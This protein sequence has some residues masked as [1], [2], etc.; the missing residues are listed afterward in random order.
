[1][2]R[3]KVLVTVEVELEINPEIIEVALTSE[4]QE[5]FYRMD[6]EADV[7]EHLIY[8]CAFH[9]RPLTALDGWADREDSDLEVV[10]YVIEEVEVI[11]SSAAPAQGAL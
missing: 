2:A 8:N 3:Y 4:W 10:R 7:L 6:G 9:H 11:E 5:H 1:M